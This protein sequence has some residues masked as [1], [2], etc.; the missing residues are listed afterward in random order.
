MLCSRTWLELGN[1][2]QHI[3]RCQ[4][5]ASKLINPCINPRIEIL[6]LSPFTDEDTVAQRDKVGSLKPYSR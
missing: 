5:V 4:V 6:L 2:Y 1:N 3:L